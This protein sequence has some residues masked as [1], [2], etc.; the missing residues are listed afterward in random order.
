MIQKCPFYDILDFFLPE[1]KPTVEEELA[2]YK[3]KIMKMHEMKAL[4]ENKVRK[5]P[6]LPGKAEAANKAIE[7]GCDTDE[8]PMKV[9]EEALKRRSGKV[10]GCMDQAGK[11][12]HLST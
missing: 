9:L 6:K 3:Y 8:D 5:G 10:C 2:E 7:T 11:D 1:R 4:N 12:D